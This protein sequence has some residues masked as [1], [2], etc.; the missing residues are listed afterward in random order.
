MRNAINFAVI[1][2]SAIALMFSQT[3]P[4]YAGIIGTDQFMSQQQVELDRETIRNVLE[5]DDARTLLEKHGVTSLQAHERINAMTDEEVRVFTQKF[6][7]LPTGG[8]FGIVAAVLV[9]VLLFIALE[10][11]GKTD[12]FNGL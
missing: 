7:Q 8:S 6:E 4:A 10:L 5:R 3:M 9:L 12:V 1:Y 2:I 11:S